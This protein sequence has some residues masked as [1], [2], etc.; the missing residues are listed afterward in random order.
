MAF[1][2]GFE[3][4]YYGMMKKG[5]YLFNLY[6]VPSYSGRFQ[7]YLHSYDLN[8]FFLPEYI[9][10][11]TLLLQKALSKKWIYHSILFQIDPGLP[12]APLPLDVSLIEDVEFPALS[13]EVMDLMRR[14]LTA[15]DES[16]HKLQDEEVPPRFRENTQTPT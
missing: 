14:H 16:G 11:I 1:L 8:M 4:H 5:G 12:P 10:P 2:L 6:T 3:K 9:Y 15:N 7:Y 13:E